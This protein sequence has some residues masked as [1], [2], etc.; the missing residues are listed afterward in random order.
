LHEKEELMDGGREMTGEQQRVRRMTPDGV[1]RRLDGITEERVR[2][3]AGLPPSELSRRLQ[4]LERSWTIER[5]L[6]TNAAAL[7]LL[8]LTLGLTRDRRWFA[9]PAVVAGFLLQHGVQGWCPPLPLFRGLGA[10]ARLEVEQERVALKALRG[11]FDGGVLAADPA[12]DPAAAL[13]PVRR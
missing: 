12:F 5:L 11:D 3:S 9:L 10:R 4:D 7:A 1:N 8:G 13:E 6:E 2:E